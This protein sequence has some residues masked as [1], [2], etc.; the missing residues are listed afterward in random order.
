MLLYYYCGVEDLL[1]PHR[2]TYLLV[3][4]FLLLG[5][6]F[7]CLSSSISGRK[8][9]IWL[10]GL[11]LG[12]V[13][14]LVHCPVQNLPD[15]VVNEIDEDKEIYY[16]A[17][18]SRPIR[19]RR[20]G[21]NR[22]RYSLILTLDKIRMDDKVYP[23]HTVMKVYLFQEPPPLDYGDIIWVRTKVKD[24][25]PNKAHYAFDRSYE[26]PKGYFNKKDS[27]SIRDITQ[28]GKNRWEELENWNPL[29]IIEWIRTH[30]SEHQKVVKRVLEKY[31][32]EENAQLARG[33][34]LGLKDDLSPAL[35]GSFKATGLG[36]LLAVSGLHVVLL[37]WVLHF[38]MFYPLFCLFYNFSGFIFGFFWKL[39]CPHGGSFWSFQKLPPWSKKFII[40]FLLVP[41]FYFICLVNLSPS[42][43]RASL[44]LFIL[45]ISL[46]RERSYYSILYSLFLA[47]LI[48][49]LFRPYD[50][51]TVGF[52]LSFFAVFGIG[53]G[54]Y[55]FPC[56]WNQEPTKI[57]YTYD[58]A[59]KKRISISVK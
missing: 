54:I 13:V 32:S 40:G 44:M 38:C 20:R 30:A 34:F 35:K 42:A 43:V 28:T 25:Q 7:I 23:A 57:K 58:D 15:E 26:E 39:F 6:C 4:F 56:F 48:I 36:H 49:L 29:R 50:L 2:S 33:F 16:R 51:I 14:G 18:L 3:G 24:I 45:L 37:C 53:W 9:A 55:A 47:G 22:K 41:I 21:E 8:Q 10:F 52:Q 5:L 59:F 11:C 31:L 27:V 12:P 19:W 1:L 17:Y 46:W